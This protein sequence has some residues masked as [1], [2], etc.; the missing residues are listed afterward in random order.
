MPTMPTPIPL[1]DPRLNEIE[2]PDF[3]VRPA[4]QVYL[5]ACVLK[6]LSADGDPVAPWRLSTPG[7]P[8]SGRDAPTMRMTCAVC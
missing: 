8:K 6:V 2:N 1:D 4:R 7:L 5:A 3:E